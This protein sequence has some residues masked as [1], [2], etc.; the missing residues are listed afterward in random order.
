LKRASPLL[1]ALIAERAALQ[2][3]V[4]LLEREQGLLMESQT[5][6]LLELSEQKS[7]DALELNKLAEARRALLKQ[8]LPQLTVEA[9]RAWLEVNSREGLAAWQE[10]LSLADRAQLLNNANGAVIQMKL[11]HNQ[12]TLAVLSSAVNKAN[13]Y[14]PDGQPSFSPGSGRSLGSG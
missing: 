9:I 8:H 1:A 13:L 2:K 5:D 6:Q 10:V 14:G 7:R 11:R 3:F 12:Q 4:A